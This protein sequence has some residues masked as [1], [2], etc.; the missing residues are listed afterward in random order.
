MQLRGSRRCPSG[1]RRKPLLK[2]RHRERRLAKT[3]LSRQNLHRAAVES[4]PHRARWNRPAIPRPLTILRALR[5][6][7]DLRARVSATIRLNQHYFCS[8]ILVAY[9]AA[10]SDSNN[11]IKTVEGFGVSLA[12]A[13]GNTKLM[14]K[15]LRDIVLSCPKELDPGFNL[16]LET[17]FLERLY[18]DALPKTRTDGVGK[19]II[20][21]R[22]NLPIEPPQSPRAGH[23]IEIESMIDVLRLNKLFDFESYFAA[24]KDVRK[25]I[26]LEFLQDGLLKVAA[27]RGWSTSTFQEAYKSLVSKELI[28]Y[29]SWSKSV[30]SPDR[31]H[32]AQVWCK[33]DSDAAEIFLVV[34]HRKNVVS[35]TYIVTVKPGDVWIWGAIG[36]LRWLSAKKVRLTARKSKKDWEAQYE[37]V[38]VTI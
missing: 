19:V 25:R 35:K 27:I 11:R 1:G 4:C 34:S 7:R 31:K 13:F 17:N 14:G 16:K 18:L 10:R 26:A 33:Y 12:R 38:N 2:I 37:P 20:E 29:R 23:R 6:A 3:L 36:E 30:T 15:Y 5:V 32:K 8:R 24:S 9:L 22:R 28:S 21:A